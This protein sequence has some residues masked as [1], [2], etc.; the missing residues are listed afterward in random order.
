[1]GYQI[2]IKMLISRDMEKLKRVEE[3]LVY[4]NM[5]DPTS[6]IFGR[7]KKSKKGFCLDAPTST[8]DLFGYDIELQDD[9]DPYVFTTTSYISQRSG[10]IVMA[11][12]HLHTGAVNATFSINGKTMCFADTHYGTDSNE[13]T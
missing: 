4:S 2:L 1:M 3:V 13:T 12:P 6:S 8:R 11:Q 9:G 5:C 7:N 10:K